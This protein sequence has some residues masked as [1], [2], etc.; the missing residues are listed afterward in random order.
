M[1]V[2]SLGDFA[3][4]LVTMEADIRLAQEAAVV[5]GC[6]MIQRA[7][8]RQIG[9]EQP[10][11]PP[12]KPETIAHKARGNTPLLETGELRASIEVTAPIRESAG[13]VCG[14]VGTNDPI[15]KY[16]EFGTSRIPAR[17]FLWTAVEGQERLIIEMTGKMVAGVMMNGGSNYRAMREVMH[18]LHHAWEDLKD[19]ADVD[20][21]DD[22]S[23]PTEDLKRVG[24]AAS[25]MARA[26]GR[27]R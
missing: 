16:H 2:F 26:M 19:L 10:Y 1:T 25:S 3:A 23:G 5:K 6:K 22:S 11:W 7:A 4:R 12:L 24:N 13:E 8:K 21:D 17:P 20:E 9:H 14:Y 15:G 27:L 18:L